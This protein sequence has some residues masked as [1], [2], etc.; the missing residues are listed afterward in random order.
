MRKRRLLLRPLGG[1][2]G[3]NRLQ[4]MVGRVDL[5]CAACLV[6]CL[7]IALLRDCMVERPLILAGRQTLVMLVHSVPLLTLQVERVLRRRAR[8]RGEHLTGQG[9]EPLLRSCIGSLW[10]CGGSMGRGCEAYL[11]FVLLRVD[12]ISQ[13]AV[14]RLLSSLMHELVP[15]LLLVV[16][17]V[18]RGGGRERVVLLIPA[19][20]HWCLRPIDNVGR[21]IPGLWERLPSLLRGVHTICAPSV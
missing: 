4:I 17:S 21:R 12:S 20:R 8:L 16:L 13:D 14:R 11:P 7:D 15:G 6:P 1:F 2:L 18:H 3:A 10:Q 5:L 19:W 9:S